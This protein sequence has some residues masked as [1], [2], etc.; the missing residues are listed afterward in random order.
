ME[1]KP[2]T[3]RAAVDNGACAISREILWTKVCLLGYVDPNF[4]PLENQE[5]ENILH[6]VLQRYQDCANREMQG[7]ASSW[8]GTIPLAFRSQALEL[9]KEL[10]LWRPP[11]R[12][13]R[14]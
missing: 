12:S 14:S 3:A 11:H 7:G 6:L 2:A 9:S 4:C 8:S 10:E 5:H 13:D 1:G